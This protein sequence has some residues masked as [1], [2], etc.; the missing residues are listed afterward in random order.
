MSESASGNH[1]KLSYTAAPVAYGRTFSDIP[2][3]KEIAKLCDVENVMPNDSVNIFDSEGD[4]IGEKHKKDIDKIKDILETVY[5]KI[6]VGKSLLL[7]KILHKEGGLSKVYEGKWGAPIA[8]ILRT[9][10]TPEDAFKRASLDD[11]G[12]V[13]EI[14][15]VYPRTAYQFEN[16][17]TRYVYEFDA[18]LKEIPQHE[19]KKFIV[20][21]PEDLSKMIANGEV[22]ETYMILI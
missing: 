13:P 11:I 17:S 3:S 10:E 21:D 18:Q 4:K 6:F 22:A 14:V 20:V 1:K 2:Y 8:T 5:V 9:N 7:S 19:N 16:G 12:Q 15:Q